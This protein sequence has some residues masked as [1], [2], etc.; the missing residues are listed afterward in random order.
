MIDNYFSAADAFGQIADEFL[1]ALRQ[2]KH[3][4]VEEFAQRYAEHAD[5]IRDM[6]PALELMEQAKPAED[7]PRTAP[8]RG[9]AAASATGLPGPARGRPRRQGPRVI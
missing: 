7:T 2:G 9:S 4:L 1:E 3:P 6:L 5:D 8:G